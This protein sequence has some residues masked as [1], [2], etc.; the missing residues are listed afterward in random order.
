MRKIAT[1]AALPALALALAACGD[2]DE[3]DTTTESQGTAIADP[4]T[5]YPPVATDARS[6]L[7]WAGTYEQR[8][9]DGR[10]RSLTLG[11]GDTY[12]LTDAEGV[13]T[14]GTFNWYADNSRILIQV[15]GEDMVFAIADGTIYRLSGPDAAIDGP[16]GAE[17]AW[18]E[19]IS[20][21][22]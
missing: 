16:F 12:T 20:L 6:S 4:A 19:S 13:E 2:S 15:D 1:F 22:Y 21:E 14:T 11:E 7:D 9:A 8:T 3:V 17:Q 10:I 18:Q 5:D